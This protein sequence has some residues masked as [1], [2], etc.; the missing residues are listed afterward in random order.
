VSTRPGQLTGGQSP[1]DYKVRRLTPLT[2]AQLRAVTARDIA[3]VAAATGRSITSRQA[4]QAAIQ[5][6]LELDR[7][8]MMQ[9]EQAP[10]KP[11]KRQPRAPTVASPDDP[12]APV[13]RRGARRYDWSR[14]LHGTSAPD[15]KWSHAKARINRITEGTV[16]VTRRTAKGLE[17][18]RNESTATAQIP[19]LARRY[20]ELWADYLHRDRLVGHNPFLGMSD[21]DALRKLEAEVY[22]ICDASTG[23][24]GQWWVPR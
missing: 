24:L 15:S 17:L 12:K 1:D 2:D 8:A 5:H 9:A 23:K 10:A 13:V 14:L 3:A 20:Y 18:L 19:A 7:V 22:A 6:L 11:A 21:A 4:D 16:P